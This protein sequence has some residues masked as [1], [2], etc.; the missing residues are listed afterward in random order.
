MSPD[1]LRQLSEAAR[2]LEGLAAR[3][4]R[5]RPIVEVAL[6]PA[7][8]Q[9]GPIVDVEI[10]PVSE[11]RRLGQLKALAD[12]LFDGVPTCHEVAADRVGQSFPKG[13]TRIEAYVDERPI[14]KLNERT[15][16]IAVWARDK[17][18]CR[19]C[20]RKVIKTVARVPERGEVNHIHGRI[21]A[22]RF[23]VRAAL[24]LCLACHERVTGRVNAHRLQIVP[25]ATFTI[26]Q[27]TFTDATFAVDWRTA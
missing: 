12:V 8:D 7:P 21:G 4:R 25:T 22:L 3:V 10:I 14:L 24:L 11:V 2:D 18:L 6:V 20:E 17:Y 1:R 23:E 9:L 27:G 26:E 19:H 15:F 16:K 13:K 5:L